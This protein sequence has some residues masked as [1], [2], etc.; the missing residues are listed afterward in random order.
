MQCKPTRKTRS[1]VCPLHISAQAQPSPSSS[2]LTKTVCIELL[3]A[4]LHT[5]KVL[6]NHFI[7]EMCN[8]T[9]TTI[10]KRS[11]DADSSL[12]ILLSRQC[13][14][15]TS[16]LISTLANNILQKLSTSDGKHEQGLER[17]GLPWCIL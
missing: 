9:T 17:R 11:L 16:H 7:A 3:S 5:S 12:R 13:I 6:V 8:A 2:Q 1:S 4:S 14:Y 10:K 15:L